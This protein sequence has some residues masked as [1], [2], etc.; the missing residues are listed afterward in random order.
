MGVEYDDEYVEGDNEEVILLSGENNPRE[1]GKVLKVGT[2]NEHRLPDHLDGAGDDEIIDYFL[3]NNQELVICEHFLRGTCRYG[4][5]CN[6]MHP[7]SMKPK[8]KEKKF[9]GDAECSICL[10]KVLANGKRFGLL[11]NC[12][13][14]FC[15]DC[16]RDWRATYDKKV[17]K[18]HYRTCPICRE[19]SYLVIPSNTLITDWD[20]KG[21]LIEEYTEAL[22]DIPCRHFNQGKG[23]CPF[24]NS[25]Y[26]GHWLE[27]GDWYEYPFKKTY[28]DEDGVMHEVNDDED[29]PTLAQM[30]G[31]LE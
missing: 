23:Y 6:M 18:T 7:A 5:D 12:N 1:V 4:D 17:K 3:E 29:E 25:C 27:N 8:K 2:R 20:I 28:I 26:Y 11:E 19:N 15:L 21:D 9:E 16:I 14:P 24:Q 30:I 31:G 10:E 13:H 22:G